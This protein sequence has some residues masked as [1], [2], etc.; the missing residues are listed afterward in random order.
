MIE[1]V[2]LHLNIY[3]DTLQKV[4][5]TKI[6]GIYFD[7]KLVFDFHCEQ[8]SNKISK[9]LMFLNKLKYFLLKL[10]MNRINNAL[11][12]LLLDYG[13]IIWGFTYDC[14]LNRF[15]K[16]RKRGATIVSSSHIRANSELLFKSLNWFSFK[17]RV[18]FNTC[19]FIYKCLSNL[20]SIMRLISLKLMIVKES[21][22]VLVKNSLFLKPD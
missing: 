16:L 15:I 5:N 1:L 6:L 20:S 19:V 3:W 7:D 2:D 22:L 9:R 18:N 17:N 12:S 8:L 10:A 14:H 11:V 21:D 13:S 4:T